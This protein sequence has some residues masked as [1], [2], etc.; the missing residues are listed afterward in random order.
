MSNWPSLKWTPINGICRLNGSAQVATFTA[1]F[2]M[3]DAKILLDMAIVFGFQVGFWSFFIYFPGIVN[4]PVRTRVYQDFQI[5]KFEHKWGPPWNRGFEDAISGSN[6]WMYCNGN[7]ND[8]GF[9]RCRFLPKSF[10]DEDPPS[11]TFCI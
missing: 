6:P 4:I 7:D 8:V 9:P 11:S 3:I 2:C 1:Q 5:P 10:G